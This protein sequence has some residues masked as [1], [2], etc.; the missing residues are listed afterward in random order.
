MK[1]IQRFQSDFKKKNFCQQEIGIYTN[2]I[3]I[4]VMVN[5]KSNYNSY[6]LYWFLDFHI[7]RNLTP[8]VK[9]KLIA[10]VGKTQQMVR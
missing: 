7:P 9:K 3:Y 8:L 10:L 5:I 1:S 6:Y 4:N 2:I